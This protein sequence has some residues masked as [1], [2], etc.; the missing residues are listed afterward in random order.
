M[1]SVYWPLPSPDSLG[2]LVGAD[3][4][5]NAVKDTITEWSPYYLAIISERLVD[6][7]ILPGADAPLDN[8]GKWDRDTFRNYSTVSG[9]ASEVTMAYLDYDLWR[10]TRT[11]AD[12]FRFHP[13]TNSEAPRKK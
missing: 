11:G 4:V 3:D 6:A 13:H 1:T 10:D 9:V 8:F 7:G 5:R 12:N 2:T